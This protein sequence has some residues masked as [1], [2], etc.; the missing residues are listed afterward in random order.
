MRV[1]L[2]CIA[3][4]ALATPTANAAGG[5]ALWDGVARSIRGQHVERVE[6]DG[7]QFD[8]KPIGTDGSGKR[9]IVQ[10]ETSWTVIGSFHKRIKGK[11]HVVYYELSGGVGKAP[12]GIMTAIKYRGIRLNPGVIFAGKVLGAVIPGV[13]SNDVL[14]A[15]QGY[16]DWRVGSWEAAAQKV[17]DEMA[18]QV[19]K[20][21]D[22]GVPFPR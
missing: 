17:V 9:R 15:V 14:N 21:V 12:R 11:N 8:L 3:T 20:M 13:D 5:V 2:A 16:Q 4:F 7:H 19:G 22:A 1:F 10:T 18:A 6:V